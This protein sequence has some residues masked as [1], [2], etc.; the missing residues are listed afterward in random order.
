M[1]VAE[2]A[3]V[4]LAN[5][6][7]R[8]HPSQRKL[9]LDLNF[10]LPAL[11]VV[12]GIVVLVV[13]PVAAPAGTA[14][15]LGPMVPILALVVWFAFVS[16]RRLAD[17]RDGQLVAVTGWTHDFGR[18][19]PDRDYPIMLYTRLS[20]GANEQY[21]LKAGGKEFRVYQLMHLRE[22]IQP[23]RNNTVLMTPRSK[24]LINVLPA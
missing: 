7:G 4:E 12:A 18:A 2:Q 1:S 3:E 9:V 10:W 8:L 16:G 19:R 6:Q 22:R 17:V 11:L 5:K 24:L 14:G 15:A 21:F 23:E 13:I 20:R